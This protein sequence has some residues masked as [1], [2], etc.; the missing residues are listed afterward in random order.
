MVL[1]AL[2]RE[3][4]EVGDELARVDEH[5]IHALAVLLARHVGDVSHDLLGRPRLT[6]SADSESLSSRPLPTW[7]SEPGSSGGAAL[8]PSCRS[9]ALRPVT[10][11]ITK[12][13]ARVGLDGRVLIEP[14]R[15]LDLL[16]VLRVHARI[17]ATAP[18][19]TP[20]NVTVEPGLRPATLPSYMTL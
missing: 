9:I 3:L 17:F 6:T 12:L 1:S 16:D 5:L 18:T 14:D 15:D 11:C 2:A 4:I 10:P 13:S 8:V 7:I 19:C 20:L